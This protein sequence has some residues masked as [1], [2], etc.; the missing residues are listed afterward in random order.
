M[1]GKFHLFRKNRS[2]YALVAGTFGFITLFTDAN[3]H[4]QITD[5][6]LKKDC[7]RTK[8]FI[9]CRFI[10]AE[11][12]LLEDEF[13][14]NLFVTFKEGGDKFNS[15][16]NHNWETMNPIVLKDNHYKIEGLDM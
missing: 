15:V 9:E 6:E 2:D 13:E 3:A 10:I 11:I 12:N 1:E 16:R 7:L 4:Q 8:N 5:E 14:V